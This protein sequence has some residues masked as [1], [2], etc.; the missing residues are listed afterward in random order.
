MGE[1]NIDAATT[2]ALRSSLSRRRAMAGLAAAGGIVTLGGFPRSARA[3]TTMTWMGWQG[4]E[5]PILT[6]DF[7]TTPESDLHK[8][9]AQVTIVGGKIVHER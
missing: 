4:Y 1:R 3:S 2:L 7:L 8:L 9:R 5:T 6:G